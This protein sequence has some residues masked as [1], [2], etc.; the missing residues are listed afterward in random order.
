M[1]HD[2][3]RVVPPEKTWSPLMH[4]VGLR[5]IDAAGPNLRPD[6]VAWRA[7]AEVKS[8]ETGRSQVL[9]VT[10]EAGAELILFSTNHGSER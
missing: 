5:N 8:A 7:S 4:V 3:Y 2:Y 1:A 10:T 6:L 9:E